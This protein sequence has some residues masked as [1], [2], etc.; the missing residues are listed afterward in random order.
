MSQR[1][2]FYSHYLQSHYRTH[3]YSCSRSLLA[4][5]AARWNNAAIITTARPHATDSSSSSSSSTREKK[6][7]MVQAT[8]S[9]DNPARTL[10]AENATRLHV[11][12]SQ[13]HV[14][15]KS[16]EHTVEVL[17][18]SHKQ[19]EKQLQ[20][21]QK[22]VPAIRAQLLLLEQRLT[23]V[24]AARR[25]QEAHTNEL[26]R[27]MGELRMEC[28]NTSNLVQQIEKRASL[29]SPPSSLSSSLESSAIM[30][31]E[32]DQPLSPTIGS[33]THTTPYAE[34]SLE[35]VVREAVQR[36]WMNMREDILAEMSR[37]S[38]LH[39]HHHRERAGND[40]ERG[41][42]VT[43]TS[44]PPVSARPTRPDS[45]AGGL[46]NTSDATP[47][48]SSRA[49][50]VSRLQH[51][52]AIPFHDAASGGIRVAS[53]TVLV[54]GLPFHWGAAH[55]RE[56]CER[57]ASGVEVV[58]CLLSRQDTT[59]TPLATTPRVFEVVLRDAKQAIRVMSALH[60]IA[61]P[62]SPTRGGQ[63]N[64]PTCTL[65][66]SPVI[67]AEVQRLLQTLQQAGDEGPVLS[68]S[69]ASVV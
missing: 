21:L 30:K 35:A 40:G 59:A 1:Y 33:A 65:S 56:L 18:T 57:R 50:V 52:G 61:L 6:G 42:T 54:T 49:A 38:S 60:G 9:T 28:F 68:G 12:G 29:S 19:S 66:L 10:D 62:A 44:T 20:T 63:R 58:S 41:A 26:L 11:T 24:E 4:T 17:T 32:C 31:N 22:Q 5:S 27:V 14:S 47:V 16:L 67:S 7:K 25:E 8:A 43:G 55:L 13:T 2:I 39:H 48:S 46:S 3:A 37:S 53:R 15:L 34:A 36:H 23:E 45:E 51:L 69:D 64:T